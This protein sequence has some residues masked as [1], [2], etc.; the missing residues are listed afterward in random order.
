[1]MKI[2]P[3]VIYSQASA[4]TGEYPF[5]NASDLTALP[6]TPT[7]V[8]INDT[9]GFAAMQLVIQGALDFPERIVLWDERTLVDPHFMN[10]VTKITEADL[11]CSFDSI[12]Y[13][14]D[15]ALLFRQQHAEANA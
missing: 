14:I 7:I 12:D 5:V 6:S 3:I 9:T 1:M 4:Y 2:K 15:G 8:K 10:R 13:I 11:G